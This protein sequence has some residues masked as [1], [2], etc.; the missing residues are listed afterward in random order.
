MKYKIKELTK[1][2]SGYPLQYE[3][4]LEDGRV[5]YIRY[6]WGCLDVRVSKNTTDNILDAVKGESI[7]K[8][9]IGGS[10]D[11]DMENDELI[12]MLKDIEIRCEIKNINESIKRETK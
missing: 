2:C 1:T 8:K 7:Y 4:K 10:Y 5:I 9:Y 12:S 3:G 11:G 6:R